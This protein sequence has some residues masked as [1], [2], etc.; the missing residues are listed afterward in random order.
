MWATTSVSDLA[1]LWSYCDGHVSL[2]MIGRYDDWGVRPVTSVPSR[3]VMKLYFPEFLNI[4][5]E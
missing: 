3:T 1:A 5:T 2:A 4:H